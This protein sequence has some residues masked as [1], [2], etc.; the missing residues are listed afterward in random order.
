MI[1]VSWKWVGLVAGTLVAVLIGLDLSTIYV[2]G[3]ITGTAN[4]QGL[5]FVS[6]KHPDKDVHVRGTRFAVLLP[7]PGPYYVCYRVMDNFKRI[8]H[9]TPIVS[10]TVL[11]IDFNQ[12]S[13]TISVTNVPPDF[14]GQRV[15]VYMSDK[16]G[17]YSGITG[18]NIRQIVVDLTDEPD[19]F[20]NSFDAI[21]FV[22]NAETDAFRLPC[23]F[24]IGG[25]QELDLAKA[26]R[27]VW[28]PKREAETSLFDQ[29]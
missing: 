15:T 27:C 5:V 6:K 2:R 24:T 10:D 9:Q 20:I 4:L 22:V 14:E 29:K 25:H 8:V 11:N 26:T 18:T 7:K 12:P 23:A 28:P 3:T 16:H 13:M 17:N 19:L 21:V 1:R